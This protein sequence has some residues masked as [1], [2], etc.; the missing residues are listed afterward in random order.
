MRWQGLADRIGDAAGRCHSM[1]ALAEAVCAAITQ[2][3]SFDF[4]CFATLD[5]A[6]GLITWAYR[7]RPLGV[8]DEKF[9]AIEYGE[10]DINSFAEISQRRPSAGVLSIDTAGRLDTSRRYHDFLGPRFGFSDELR[11]VFNSRGASW[12]ALAIYR[13]EGEPTFTM[14]DARKLAASGEL[15]AAAIQQV[16][17]SGD[18]DQS[19]SGAAGQTVTYGSGPAVL[20]IDADDRVTHLSPAA[21]SSV[22]DMGRGEHGSLPT[23][24]LAV[25]ASTRHH[26]EHSSARVQ[27]RSGRWL[28]LRA[29]PL[30]GPTG[31]GDV[32]VTLEPATGAELSRLALAARGLTAR[33]ED[34]AILVLRGASTR[35]ISSALH[36]SP[37]TVQDHLKGI[38]AKLGVNS[39]R[40]MIARFI[41]D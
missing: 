28:K 11:V 13:G 20:I 16:L 3:I 1:P 12:G 2:D 26:Q 10:A 37:H 39:R 15:I 5:P 36:L 41:L 22:E 33:E 38:F 19:L 9:T 32:V 7:T 18:A 21:R 31:K 27:G 30:D 4:G 34:V 25:A 14:A 40:E 6:T 35:A 8:G 24:I 17:F 23:S 29:A